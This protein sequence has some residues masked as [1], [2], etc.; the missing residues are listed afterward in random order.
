MVSPKRRQEIA[1]G[2]LAASIVG[3]TVAIWRAVR[4]AQRRRALR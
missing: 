2:A 4:R 1:L 3:I